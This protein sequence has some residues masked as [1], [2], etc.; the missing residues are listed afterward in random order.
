[1]DILLKEKLIIQNVSTVHKI[2]NL[3]LLRIV[4]LVTCLLPCM[5]INVMMNAQPLFIIIYSLI[6][7]IHVLKTVLYV[8][9]IYARNVIMEIYLNKNVSKIALK[10]I[11][12]MLK[13]VKSVNKDVISVIKI[14][15]LSARK[16]GGLRINI[17]LIIVVNFYMALTKNVL[18]VLKIVKY[19]MINYAIIVEIIRY[20][21]LTN[22]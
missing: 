1:M 6:H 9:I 10:L 19:A 16:I 8:Q 20:G 2:V 17:V 13:F 15:A 11:I 12:R 3:A 21:I 4:I 5:I 22:A 14:N 18:I 7:V